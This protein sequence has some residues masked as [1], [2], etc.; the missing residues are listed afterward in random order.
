MFLK[1]TI[2]ALGVLILLFKLNK[3]SRMIVQYI[4]TIS[5]RYYFGKLKNLSLQRYKIVKIIFT[6]MY[7]LFSVIFIYRKNNLIYTYIRRVKI[8]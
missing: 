5:M 3:K 6:K 8:K 4:V 7:I 1:V 2:T